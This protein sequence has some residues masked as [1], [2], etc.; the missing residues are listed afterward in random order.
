M[1]KFKL[2]IV[3]EADDTNYL[4]LT[5]QI[6]ETEEA[7]AKIKEMV[8]FWSGHKAKLNKY[9]GDYSKA[10]LHYLALEI[11]AE[12]D[13]L[14]AAETVVPIYNIIA[15]AEGF[16]P[17]QA[18]PWFILSNFLHCYVEPTMEIEIEEITL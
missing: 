16:Y 14:S 13:N 1:R 15:N 17:L 18:E 4:S 3:E 12:K 9:S 11:E 7:K 6:D 8:E 2:K 10:F 5:V